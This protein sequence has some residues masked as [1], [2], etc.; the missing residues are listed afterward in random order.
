MGKLQY[1]VLRYYPSIIAGESINLGVLFSDEESGIREFRYTKNFSRVRKFDDELNI[2][3][4]RLLLQSIKDE[5]NITIY[6]YNIKF[7]LLSFIKYY[8][9]E[10]H[11]D[12]P[13]EITYENYECCAD[14][15]LKMYLRYDFD[16]NKRPTHEQ[17]IA[18]LAKLLTEREVPFKRNIQRAGKY[19]E[20]ISYDYF[21]YDYGVKFFSFTDKNLR[22]LLNDVKA[23]AWN[24]E[25]SE[26]L[27]K[28][29]IFY[30]YV[31]SDEKNDIIFH[32]IMNILKS[33]TKEVYSIE[34]G[35]KLLNSINK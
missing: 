6:N 29:M 22:R 20:P 11:F 35:I 16:K 10:F 28:T 1:S 24:C 12:T 17:Q 33:A 30:D 31:K 25:H 18:F 14:E 27:V 15:I 34:D 23:W 7:D 32:Y 9:N 21:F 3:N 4:L 8:V 26:N 19:S 2:D 13:I 5:I